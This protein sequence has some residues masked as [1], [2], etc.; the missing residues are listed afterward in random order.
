MLRL[1]IC[2]VSIR[3]KSR[4][5]SRTSPLDSK[6]HQKRVMRR[7]TFIIRLIA[8]QSCLF[9]TFLNWGCNRKKV[10]QHSSKVQK[11]FLALAKE[12]DHC[13]SDKE[14]GHQLIS[15]GINYYKVSQSTDEWNGITMLEGTKATSFQERWIGT[16]S[17]KNTNHRGWFK[18]CVHA[19][20][21]RLAEIVHRLSTRLKLILSPQRTGEPEVEEAARRDLQTHL[22]QKSSN[23]NVMAVT[24]Q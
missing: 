23:Q 7:V 1:I 2:A 19:V 22:L 14:S 5:E 11:F 4:E 16:Q 10:T 9:A 20:A 6:L 21:T 3:S 12:L 15:L 8:F 17:S 13:S 18:R 24:S